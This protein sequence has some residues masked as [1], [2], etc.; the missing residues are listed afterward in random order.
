MTLFIFIAMRSSFS[1]QCKV[2]PLLC[3][4]TKH[5]LG[6][7]GFIESEQISG[8]H[9]ERSGFTQRA[10]LG[11]ADSGADP[12]GLTRPLARSAWRACASCDSVAPACCRRR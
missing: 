5:Q 3:A 2:V 8:G 7:D 12:W 10:V 11:H 1:A 9:A 6:H 4:R